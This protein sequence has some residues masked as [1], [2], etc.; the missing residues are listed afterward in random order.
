MRDGLELDTRE[1]A[2]VG[3]CIRALARD[4]PPLK[5]Q[6][7]MGILRKA[8]ELLKRGSTGNP[9]ATIIGGQEIEIEPNE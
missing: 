1:Q 2:N 8:E 4:E 9:E 5:Q 3:R 6:R 7:V